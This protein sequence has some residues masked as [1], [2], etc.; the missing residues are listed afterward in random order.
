MSGTEEGERVEKVVG[1]G[2]HAL[3]SPGTDPLCLEPPICL[4]TTLPPPDPGRGRRRGVNGTLGPYQYWTESGVKEMDILLR[5]PVLH[6]P[7]EGVGLPESETKGSAHS[8][9]VED[10]R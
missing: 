10:L 9:S 5:E 2:R 8:G 7:T 4:V 3:V 1:S 6:Y